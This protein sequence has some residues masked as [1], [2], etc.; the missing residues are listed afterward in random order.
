MRIAVFGAGGVGGYF[1]G[2]LAQAG[3]DV[4]F[5]ARGAHLQ[6]LRTHGLQVE[7]L[8]GDFTV[9]P[10]QATDDPAQIGVVDAVVVGVKA[11]QVPDVAQAMAPLVGADTYVVPLQNGLEAAAQLA[12]VLGDRHVLGGTCAIYSFITAPGCIR[13]I[14]LEPTVT[15]G[16]LDTRPSRRAESWR[17]ALDRAGIAA[18]VAPDIHV[19]MWEKFLVLR[20]GV[21]GAV[22]RAP[23][24]VLR[25]VPET[26]QM[27]EQA[28]QEVVA[29]AQ[30]RGITMAADIMQRNMALLESLP[31]QATTSLQRD[32]MTEH[33]SELEAQAGA[34]V[35]LGQESG[36]PTPLHTFLY[37]SLLPMERRVRH[38]VQFPEDAIDA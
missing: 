15:I 37:H 2:R 7:S 9:S 18:V 17:R 22:T 24:G 25:S 1:G 36:M 31:P 11:W 33:P 34:L 29:V 12:A 23:A 28:G 26:R 16:E 10:V 8:K 38:Q 35:R 3:E 20:W 13:H 27:I 30:R 5:I 4:V 32:I 6:A 21:I 14:G 19:P